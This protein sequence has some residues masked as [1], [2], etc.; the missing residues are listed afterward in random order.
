MVATATAL[1]EF[2]TSPPRASA[3]QLH[4]SARVI[5]SKSRLAV[6]VE[7]CAFVAAVAA[8]LAQSHFRGYPVEVSD[9]KINF[10]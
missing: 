2:S 1:D 7:S 8:L 9:G 10:L 3:H 5:E 6:V 4:S